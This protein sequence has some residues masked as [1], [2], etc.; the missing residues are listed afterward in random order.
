[1]YKK[2]FPQ[3]QNKNIFFNTLNLGIQHVNWRFE[4]MGEGGGKRDA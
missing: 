4:G 3:N 2:S 1:M